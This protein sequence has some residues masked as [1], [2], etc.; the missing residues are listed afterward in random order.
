MSQSPFGCILF[1]REIPDANTELGLSQSVLL[2]FHS[3]RATASEA[4]PIR[5]QTYPLFDIFLFP[6]LQ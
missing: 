1:T 6:F 5:T 3:F 4:I 2:F